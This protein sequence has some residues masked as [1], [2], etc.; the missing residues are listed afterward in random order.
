MDRACVVNDEVTELISGGAGAA[1]NR[2][3]G[4]SSRRAGDIQKVGR[5]GSG[6]R[7]WVEEEPAEQGLSQAQPLDRDDHAA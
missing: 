1:I 4:V 3:G 7:G 2:S 6:R 5:R